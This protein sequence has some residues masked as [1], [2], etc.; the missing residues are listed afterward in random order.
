V[1]IEGT[2]I[3]VHR[4]SLFEFLPWTWS[5]RFPWQRHL[6]RERCP[7]DARP[8]ADAWA[9]TLRGLVSQWAP[10]AAFENLAELILSAAHVNRQAAGWPWPA[11]EGCRVQRVDVRTLGATCGNAIRYLP[12]EHHGMCAVDVA[13]RQWK[14]KGDVPVQPIWPGFAADSLVHGAVLWTFLVAPGA[15]RH[16]VRRRRGLCG[17]CAYPLK[18]SKVCAECGAELRGG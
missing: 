1:A 17:S 18:G 10:R 12:A 3:G 13:L 11:L 2:S 14:I 7:I 9:D 6:P 4:Q 8:S 15:W 5:P 16:L